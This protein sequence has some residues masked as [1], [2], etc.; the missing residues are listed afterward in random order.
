MPLNKNILIGQN[1]IAQ[2]ENFN[3]RIDVLF[4]LLTMTIT[5]ISLFIGLLIIF[6]F[7]STFFINKNLYLR[8]TLQNQPAFL[9]RFS[10]CMQNSLRFFRQQE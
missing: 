7:V 8:T 1:Y 4:D 6:Y 3:E 2:L 10:F 9:T 5:F